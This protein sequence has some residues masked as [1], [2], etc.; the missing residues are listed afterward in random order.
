MKNINYKNK[1]IVDLVRSISNHFG[2]KFENTDKIK[3]L[4]NLL[5]LKKKVVLILIDGLGY[6]KIQSLNDDSI[7]KRNCI[8]SLQT[9]N[10]SSTATFLTTLYTAEYPEKHGILGW[11]SYSKLKNL[12]YHSLLLTDRL[13]DKAIKDYNINIEDLTKSTSVFE[14]YNVK[15]NMLMHKNYFNSN[16]SMYFTNK[17]S[18]RIGFENIED[19]FN[20]T[21]ISSKDYS[22]THIYID[23]VDSLSHYYGVN[24]NEVTTAI[25]EIETNL[26]EFVE[27]KDD[28]VSIVI[29]ADHGQ[30]DMSEMLYLNNSQDYTKYFYALPSS[31]TRTLSFFVKTKFINEFKNNF[32]NEFNKDFELF[33]K[34]EISSLH[35]FGNETNNELIEDS[36]G[37]FIAIAKGS[38]FMVCDEKTKIEY[39]NIIGNHSGVSKE[40]LTIPLIIL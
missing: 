26:K 8:T 32:V 24:S 7:L 6:Y 36:L 1:D 9:V 2:T 34:Q 14:K 17:Y 5:N 31:D 21:L 35:L 4:T 27:K 3:D 18:D 22:F 40:E 28:D 29:I 10:P 13:T 16:Y 39:S 15:T 19:A 23:D 37:E 25:K 38:K 33:S 30:I 11:W 12:N 20:K